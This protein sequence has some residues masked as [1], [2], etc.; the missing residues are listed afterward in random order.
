MGGF[1][2]T[3]ESRCE[4]RRWWGYGSIDQVCS[5]EKARCL[6]SGCAFTI[7]SVDTDFWD[8]LEK[9]ECGKEAEY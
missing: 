2:C 4:E 3:L 1:N 8:K 6:K 7:E 5:Y 9:G